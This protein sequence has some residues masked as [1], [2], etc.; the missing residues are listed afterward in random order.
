MVRFIFIN[1][2][3]GEN[4]DDLKQGC[5]R[6]QNVDHIQTLRNNYFHHHFIAEVLQQKVTDG[7]KH[8]PA[9]CAD[10]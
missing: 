6:Q 10:I 1:I 3:H 7:R 5:F 2:K 8:Q 9:F 4:W